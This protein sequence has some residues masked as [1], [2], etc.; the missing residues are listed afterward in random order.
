MLPH[1]EFTEARE[2]SVLMTWIPIRLLVLRRDV[3]FFEGA[4][5]K[6]VGPELIR[7]VAEFLTT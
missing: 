7:K 3:R 6:G 2:S 4:R 5:E 1:A